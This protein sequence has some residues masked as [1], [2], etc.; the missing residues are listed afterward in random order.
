MQDPWRTGRGGRGWQ[1]ATANEHPLDPHPAPASAA[2]MA[3]AVA[4]AAATG[5]DY[6]AP[7]PSPKGTVR[8][9]PLLRP[10]PHPLRPLADFCIYNGARRGARSRIPGA[11]PKQTKGTVRTRPLPS[12]APA[13]SPPVTPTFAS[14][15]F[16][17]PLIGRNGR[18]SG[19][20]HSEPSKVVRLQSWRSSEELQHESPAKNTG[21]VRGM[22]GCESAASKPATCAACRTPAAPRT[23]AALAQPGLEELHTSVHARAV[24][25][26][27]LSAEH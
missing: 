3:T 10:L 4:A 2:A 12:S 18:E 20:I 6:P 1:H 24:R 22:L 17:D 13:P 14:S 11:H 23:P 25:R 21:K 16:L 5:C 8:T 15:L 26:E 19:D 27:C 7:T 9:R